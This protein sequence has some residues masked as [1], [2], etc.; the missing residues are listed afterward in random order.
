MAMVNPIM[1]L[2]QSTTYSQ[3]DEI[4]VTSEEIDNLCTKIFSICTLFL[5]YENIPFDIYPNKF[6]YFLLFVV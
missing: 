2:I 3:P 4:L 1:L 5:Q 6:S